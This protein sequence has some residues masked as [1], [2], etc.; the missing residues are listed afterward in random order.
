[1]LDF[2]TPAPETSS[3]PPRG[4]P[5]RT[6][7][8]GSS[9]VVGI[10]SN[11]L[12]GVLQLST[13]FAWEKGVFRSSTSRSSTRMDFRSFCTFSTGKCAFLVGSPPPPQMGMCPPHPEPEILPKRIAQNLHRVLRFSCKT[14]DRS[15]ISFN[16]R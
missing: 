15:F 6:L 10:F 4:S 5:H 1:M 14:R 9:L 8:Y 7:G 16:W 11:P 12:Q 3:H 13:I 2:Y